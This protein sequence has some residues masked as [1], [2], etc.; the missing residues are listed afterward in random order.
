MLKIWDEWKIWICDK[1]ITKNTVAFLCINSAKVLVFFVKKFYPVPIRKQSYVILKEKYL[2]NQTSMIPQLLFLKI[3]SNRLYAIN[4]PVD[5]RRCSF[6]VA[7]S[8]YLFKWKD[9]RNFVMTN[10]NWNLIKIHFPL[11]SQTISRALNYDLREE[12]KPILMMDGI[13]F[14]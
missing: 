5:N 6:F 1:F 12:K 9:W 7:H 14:Y 2:N 11:T 4:F 8:S 13:K 10:F 3:S